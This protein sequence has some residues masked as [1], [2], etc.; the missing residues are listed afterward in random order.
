M[1]INKISMVQNQTWAESEMTTTLISYCL[2]LT[3]LKP[4][5]S[6][7]FERKQRTCI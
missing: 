4:N 1:L 2:K 3:G 5:L 6:F 7:E